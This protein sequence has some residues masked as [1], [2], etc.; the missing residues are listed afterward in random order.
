MTVRIV[1]AADLHLDSPLRGLAAYPDAPVERLRAASRHAFSR[2]VDI[3]VE[4]NA[5]LMLL[6]GDVWDGD[7]P[8][9]GT[10]LFF[11]REMGRLQRANVR[12]VLLRGNHDA[13]SK[14]TKSVTLPD[15]VHVLSHKKPESIPFDDLGVVVHGQSFARPDVTENL[16]LAYPDAAAGKINV[17]MLHTALEGDVRH[18]TYAPCKLSDLQAKRYDYWA[19]GHVHEHAILAASSASDGGTIAFPGVLQGRQVRETG[20][21]GALWVELDASGSRL[22]RL[23]VD[24]VRWHVCD[25]DLDAAE[26]FEEIPLRVRTAI[27]ALL[28]DA[29]AS[30]DERL[31]A[32]RLRLLGRTPLH[33]RLAVEAARVR[34]SAIEAVAALSPD[35]IF[36]EKIERATEPELTAAELAS[37]RD[38]LADLQQVLLRCGEDDA[39]RAEIGAHLVEFWNQLPPDVRHVLEAN[40]PRVTAAIVDGRTDALLPAAHAAVMA[41]L[42][43]GADGKD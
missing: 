26:Q 35:G 18:A 27:E 3:T 13:E 1:H 12:V 23:I 43:D 10:G 30:P 25:V 38:A 20:A 21:K 4:R 41:L 7:W 28:A 24:V 29:D 2:L 31:L 14:I 15:N 9:V 6:A 40:E 42:A 17:G 39:L 19:L 8:D 5:D 34:E 33:G 11:A 36:L 32:L 37:R 16:A 22:E